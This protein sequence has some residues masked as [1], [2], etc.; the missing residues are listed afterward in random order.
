MLP[1]EWMRNNIGGIGRQL[2]T[3]DLFPR[4]SICIAVG[5]VFAAYG[6]LVVASAAGDKTLHL[7]FPGRGFLDHYGFQASFLSTPLVLLTTY[8]AV[9]Y[10]LRL[11]QHIDLLVV[12][13]ADGKDLGRII[14]P[15]VRSLFLKDKW[16]SALGLFAFIGISISLAIFRH[17]ADPVAFWGN[18]VFNAIQY[19]RGFVTAN[20]YLLVTWG[21]VYPIALFCAIQ[22]TCSIE[23]IASKLRKEKLLRMDFLHIDKCGGMSKFGT[24]N[25]MIMV[26]YLWPLIAFYALHLTHRYT[27]ASLV[28][29]GVG[30]SAAFILQSI[31]G[32]H[33]ISRAISQEKAVLVESLNHQIELA[34]NSSEVD[35]SVAIARLAYRDQVLAV[36]S[37]PYSSKVNVAVNLLRFAPTVIAFGKTFAGLANIKAG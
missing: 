26:I 7:P 17:L 13:G 8:I 22:M 4:K 25:L 1:K 32:I 29:G 5:L 10:F 18:D 11:L 16:A 15:R 6:G 19:P 2:F 35:S 9:G 14:G 31:Y 33:W 36:A 37:Y 20:V 24:L 27:Y 21:V 30:I 28:L 34:M 23:I 12:K 3:K